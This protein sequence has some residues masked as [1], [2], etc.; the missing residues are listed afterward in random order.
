MPAAPRKSARPRTDTCSQQGRG[1][2]IAIAAHPDDIEFRMAGTLL[3]LAR[4]G[5]EIHYW[6]LSAGNCGSAQ[7]GPAETARRR[8]KEARRA[9][10]ILGAY[11]HPP[12]TRDLEIAYNVPNVRRVASVI[13]KVQPTVILTHPPVDYME[14][15]TETCRLVVSGAF[16]HAMPNFHVTPSRPTYPH[17]VTIYHCMPHGLC[18]P[19]GRRVAPAF[20]VDTT[21]V[22]A[23]KMSALAAHASQQHWLDQSQRMNSYLQAGEDDSIQL[24]SASGRCRHAEA[25][26]Q[27]SHMG[28]CSASARPLQT[29]LVGVIHPHNS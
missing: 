9:A 18:D 29:A 5:W 15:H 20:Y 8:R 21:D 14:D 26:W 17:D 3:L 13:R 25:F 27:H 23:T 28:F 16:A 1:I 10:S 12:I 6:N 11:W 24:G 22:H 19:Y 2:A 4:R 7:Y